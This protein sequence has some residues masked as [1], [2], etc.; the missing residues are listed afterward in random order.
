MIN[1]GE[2]LVE[3]LAE[4]IDICIDNKDKREIVAI[5]EQNRAKDFS[6]EA[7]YKNFVKLLEEI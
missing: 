3:D 2:L 7:F 4:A 1:R 6:N 5:E